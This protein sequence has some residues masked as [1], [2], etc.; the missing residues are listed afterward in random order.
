MNIIVINGLPRSGKDTF[1]EL[2]QDIIGEKRCL[3][4]STV[5]FVKEVAAVC[6][7]DKTK[8]PENRAFLSDLKDLLTKW[9][10][11]PYKDVEQRIKTFKRQLYFN[12]INE[13]DAI[14]F[15]H[16]REP[17]EIAKFV[18][19][20]GA[21][22]LLVTRKAVENAE[23]SNHADKEVF[24]HEYDCVVH[25]NGTIDDLKEVA[26]EFLSFLFIK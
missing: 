13:S 6:G 3:N 16:C 14:V 11:V 19:R 15:I 21:K 1:V 20:M 22:T 8:T 25:N 9:N 2:C 10:D 12:S 18:D 5:D 23:Q 17:Q 4:V 24:N 26:R 7:W